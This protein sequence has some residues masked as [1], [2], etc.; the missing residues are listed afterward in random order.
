MSAIPLPIK[1]DWP[2]AVPNP[3]FNNL[4]NNLDQLDSIDDFEAAFIQTLPQNFPSLYLEGFHLAQEHTEKKWSKSPSAFVSLTGWYFAEPFKFLAADKSEKGCRL[5][6]VQHG[7][8]Y[9]TGRLVPS[10]VHELEISDSYMVWGWA[11]DD[12]QS[13]HNLPSPN[14]PSLVANQRTGG[15]A[16]KQGPI[17]M[18]TTAHP[19]F[20]LRFQ[21]MPVGSQWETYFDWRHRFLQ[22]LPTQVRKSI[23]LRTGEKDYGWDVRSRT[24]DAFP[25]IGWDEGMAY[26][27]RLKSSRIIVADYPGT[28]FLESMKAN[29][30]TVLFWDSQQW[31]I[32]EEAEPYFDSLREDG[33]LWDSPEAA[34]THA[35]SIFEDPWEWW[36]SQRIQQAR[37]RFLDRFGFAQEDWAKYWADALRE[38]ASIG[39]TSDGQKARD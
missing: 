26:H 29:V 15:K 12:V 24:S 16:S 36:G 17:V 38:E 18:V 19:R 27:Q 14:L 34:G 5:V 3:V 31:E 23:L 8:L 9:G 13:Q 33:I 30:P 1:N 2:F 22:V 20:L 28:T 37:Q 11:A 39:L 25:E 21:S 35:A 10:E 4:R 32:R 6:A 7:G